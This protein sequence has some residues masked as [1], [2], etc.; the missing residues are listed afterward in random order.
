MPP[1]TLT[2]TGCYEDG[3]GKLL[4]PEAYGHPAKYSRNLIRRIY[5]HA[6]E[7]GMLARGGTILDP[8]GGVAL[9]ALDAQANGLHWVGI[10]LEPRFCDLAQQNL[11]VAFL[12]EGDARG[13]PARVTDLPRYQPCTAG[14][15]VPGLAAVRQVESRSE[16]RLEH[17]LLGCDEQGA[18]VWLYAYGVFLAAQ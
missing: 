10:E 11:A 2:W 16:R 1:A 9:G 4:V 12:F 5:Q 17:G 3:W 15:A 14:A 18:V 7:Q 6:L 13:A 8:F